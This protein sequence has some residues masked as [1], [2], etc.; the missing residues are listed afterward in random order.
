MSTFTIR[1][2]EVAGAIVLVFVSWF[3][4]RQLVHAAIEA[5]R[6]FW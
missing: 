5:L 6:A 4:D 2:F 3:V 1:E